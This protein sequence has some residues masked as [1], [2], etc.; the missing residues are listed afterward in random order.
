[1][2]IASMDDSEVGILEDNANDPMPDEPADD[3]LIAEIG[4]TESDIAF[5]AV[6][7]EPSEDTT[8]E[9]AAETADGEKGDE[10][11]SQE[12]D[13]APE[14]EEPVAEPG[15][16][17]NKRIQQLVEENKTLQA[18]FDQRLQAQQQQMYQYMEQQRQQYEAQQQQVMQQYQ[19]MMQAQAQ[20]EEDAQLDEVGKFKKNVLQ[21]AEERAI[22][23]L[24]PQL[25][26]LQNQLQAQQQAAQ[27]AQQRAEQQARL[28]NFTAQASRAREQV[29][30]AG[31]DAG[32]DGK[33]NS[34]MD[35]MLLSYVAA[36]NIP[37]EQ[38]ALKFRGM[39]DKIYSARVKSGTK[40]A[41]AP[42]MK[43]KGKDIP[44]PAAPGRRVAGTAYRPSW[45]SLVNAGYDN[46]LDWRTD[47]SPK[48]DE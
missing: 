29:L 42:T 41:A 14:T 30:M 37:P 33:D 5:D 48:L 18:S 22:Q 15:G 46:Y 16:R 9:L 28:D 19:A 36:T 20:K 21:E 17:A 12:P 44:P 34:I 1:M 32:F 8:D 47:G 35:D 6:E 40:R 23:K 3:D 25:Q 10:E 27:Q 43:P 24:S 2:A 11:G 7:D 4:A 13:E 26:Q 39:I 31:I 45:E 38:A